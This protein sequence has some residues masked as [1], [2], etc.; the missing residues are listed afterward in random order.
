MIMLGLPSDNINK[1]N[2]YND[3]KYNVP[4]IRDDLSVVRKKLMCNLIDY[5]SEP[6]IADKRIIVI[7]QGMGGVGK[8][9]LRCIMPSMLNIVIPE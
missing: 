5:F 8:S 9:H 3:N 7:C 1:K 4:Q 2:I 6:P